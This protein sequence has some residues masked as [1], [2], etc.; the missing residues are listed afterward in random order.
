VTRSGTRHATRASLVAG[1]L[2]AL[3]APAHAGD[4][5]FTLAPGGAPAVGSTPAFVAAADLNGD[6]DPDLVTANK[7]AA[8]VS[9]LIGDGAGGFTSAGAKAVGSNPESVAVA[10]LNGDGNQDLVTANYLVDTSRYSS[11]TAR[12][13]SRPRPRSPSATARSRS[14]WAISTATAT[15]T[16]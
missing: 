9:V 8:S 14:P 12:G 13:G 5:T 16:S 4:G 3:A 11:A 6:G 10:D 7:N 15:R 1:A 2:L